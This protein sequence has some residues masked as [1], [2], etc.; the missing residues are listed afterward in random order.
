MSFDINNPRHRAEAIATAAG[1]LC[2]KYP[3]LT[4][5]QRVKLGYA[6]QG[7]FP[8]MDY[9]ALHKHLQG[10]LDTQKQCWVSGLSSKEKDALRDRV[11]K[12]ILKRP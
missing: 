11:E 7:E 10:H 1:Y 2:G 9:A 12:K 8:D 4:T 3:N 6:V 5:K